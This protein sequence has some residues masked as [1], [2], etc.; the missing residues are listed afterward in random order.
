M[1]YATAAEIKAA[2][3]FPSTGAPVSD[4]D[5]T[6]FIGYAEEEI[7]SIYHTKFGN[8]EATKTAV[9]GSTTT[10]VNAAESY[11]DSEY[12]GYV[13]WVIAG[14]NSGEYRE[15]SSNDT[16][17]LTVSPAFTAAVDDTTQFRITKLGYK[18]ETVDGT[19][20]KYQFVQYQPLIKL[21]ALTID[22]TDVTPS[23]VYQYETGRLTMSTSAEATY[24]ANNNPQLVELKY[25]YGVY[26]IPQIIKRLCIVIASIRTLTAQIAGTYDD[27]TSV[28]LPG[29]LQGNKGEP[30]LNIQNALNY[31]Q[32][33]A[34]GIV[35][36]TKAEGAVTGD[37]RTSTSYRPF[38][39]FG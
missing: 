11:T 25:I 16:T 6:S 8:V 30:Y 12:I 21:N 26:P 24:F 36:G 1:G 17:T 22:S 33:E 3:N 2:I 20:E 29:G 18:D 13:V 39:L 10:L 14:T 4:A 28:S 38:T 15:I 35:Y 19:G 7:E 23:Y 5:I 34:R 37:W 9:S 31:L 32:G 27:W